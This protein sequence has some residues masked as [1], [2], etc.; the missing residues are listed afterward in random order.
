MNGI[1]VTIA[2][3]TIFA[4]RP[5][6]RLCQIDVNAPIVM[7]RYATEN[8]FNGESPKMLH[9]DMMRAPVARTA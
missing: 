7:T 8:Q 9:P 6:S 3:Q 2:V 1:S 4:L 5:C